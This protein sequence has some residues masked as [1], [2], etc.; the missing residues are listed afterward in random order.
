MENPTC[1]ATPPETISALLWT[2]MAV[3]GI[4]Y[5]LLGKLK[6]LKKKNSFKHYTRMGFINL[7]R[8]NIALE[9]LNVL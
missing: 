2:T 7:Y 8:K 4:V 1:P 5:A 9:I 6:F 3:F